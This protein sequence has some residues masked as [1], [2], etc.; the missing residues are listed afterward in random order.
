MYLV[1]AAVFIGGYGVLNSI[2]VGSDLHQLAYLGSSLACVGALSGLA[3]QK[4]SRIGI[5]YNILSTYLFPPT[6]FVFI[7]PLAWDYY[8]RTL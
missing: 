3:S 7:S 8:A 5:Q 1:P 4:T 6:S 2:G